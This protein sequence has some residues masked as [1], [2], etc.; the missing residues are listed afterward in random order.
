MRNSRMTMSSRCVVNL[1]SFPLELWHLPLLRLKG[2][3]T[4]GTSMNNWLCITFLLAI[5][6]VMC[7]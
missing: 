4:S 5:N 7:F 1:L 6:K 3:S 2:V